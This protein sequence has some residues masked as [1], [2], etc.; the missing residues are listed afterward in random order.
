MLVVVREKDHCA[1]FDAKA[2]LLIQS[3]RMYPP[4]SLCFRFCSGFRPRGPLPTTRVEIWKKAVFH[5]TTQQKGKQK[6]EEQKRR[7]NGVT[8]S[9]LCRS[10]LSTRLG[11][12]SPTCTGHLPTRLWQ[13]LSAPVLPRIDLCGSVHYLPLG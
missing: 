12:V 9:P 1:V 3:F 11:L 5:Q 8:G 7:T 4:F 13:A 6:N 2:T 10:T